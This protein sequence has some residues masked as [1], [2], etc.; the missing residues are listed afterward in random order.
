MEILSFVDDTQHNRKLSSQSEI[1]LFWCEVFDFMRVFPGYFFWKFL[2]DYPDF[3]KIISGKF[4]GN[5][6]RVV[7][8][9]GD[10]GRCS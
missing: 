5:P 8:P 6:A 4:R 9:P 7:C 2:K 1:S 10:P 3:L